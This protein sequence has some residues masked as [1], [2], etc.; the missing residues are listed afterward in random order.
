[1]SAK[2]STAETTV[3]YQSVAARVATLYRLAS[4]PAGRRTLLLTV[5]GRDLLPAEGWDGEVVSDFV[6][7]GCDNLYRHP[8]ASFDRVVLHWSFGE[9]VATPPRR[10]SAAQRAELLREVRRILT[11][12]G[13]IAGCAANYLIPAEGL[14][15]PLFGWTG[16]RLTREL[17]TAGFTRVRVGTV[18]PSADVPWMLISQDR[19]AARNYFRLHHG[20]N[21]ETLGLLSRWTRHLLVEIGLAPHL[22]GSVAFSGRAP[23]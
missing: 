22:Q 15:W 16:G 7:Y 9:F 13:V 1:M 12:G 2:D 21:R 19:R 3:I 5:P 20:R 10:R 6:G 17:T 18:L 11:P 8:D 4:V 23:C 14:R